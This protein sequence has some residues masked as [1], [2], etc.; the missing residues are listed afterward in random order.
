VFAISNQ[1]LEKKWEE[2]RRS[3]GDDVQESKQFFHGTSLTCD[4]TN[5]QTLCDDGN[6]GICGISSHGMDPDQIGSTIT[7]HRYGNGYYFAEHSS[8]SHDYTEG[9]HGY[10]GV[11]LCDI[12]P[13]KQYIVSDDISLSGLPEGFDSVYGQI[14]TKFSLPE[15][16][17]Y[18]PTAVMPRYIIVYK[19][20]IPNDC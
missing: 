19:E 2:Y 1:S 4:I 15:I 7:R 16:A 20:P 10:R 14:D 17:V 12:L 5:T 18:N 3:L 9:A 6:C 8:K 11:L 13:G